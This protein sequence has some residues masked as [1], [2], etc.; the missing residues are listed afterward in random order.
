MN[1]STE[2]W[3]SADGPENDVV[4]ST[5]IRLARNFVNFPFPSRFSRDDGERIQ[6][7]VFDAFSR[8]EHPE[9]YQALSV[10]KLDIL[11]QRILAERGVLA[12]SQTVNPVAGIVVRTD[13]KLV[14][15]VNAEDH[16]RLS[17]FGAGLNT[18]CVYPE[19]KQIDDGLQNIIQFAA[20]VDFGYLNAALDNTGTGMKLSFFLHLP[21]LTF[22]NRETNELTALIS[23]SEQKGLHVKACFGQ[24]LNDEEAFSPVLGNC[25]ELSSFRCFTGSEEEQIKA[26]E[27]AAFSF[28]ESERMCRRKVAD[29]KPTALRDLV[30]KAL[31]QVKYSRFLSEREC[32]QALF[33]IK[34]GND[35]GILTGMNNSSLFS[36]VYRTKEA[37]IE[38]INRSER[39]KFESDV[40]T[41]RKKETD[42]KREKEKVRR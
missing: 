37:H 33:R 21:S 28:I 18:A 3:Y 2:A 31:A 32:L 24:A 14:C 40:V 4:L 38:F 26:L 25:Y 10:K 1:E 23:D 29:T 16:V 42:R 39:F 9:R 36:L 17:C 12:V 20:S 7:L 19:I 13:G 34:W 11:G 22:F 27:E 5:R 30:Y 35:T 6:T 8:L 41:R 15:A